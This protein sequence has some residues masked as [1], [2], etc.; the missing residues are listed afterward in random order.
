M[1]RQQLLGWVL[2][3]AW[4]VVI[5]QFG[6]SQVLGATPS[7]PLQ[8]WLLRKSMHLVVYGVLGGAL[9]LAM[10]GASRWPWILGL[11]LVI[12]LGD[13]T[14]QRF[15]PRRAFNLHDIGVDLLGGLVGTTV[16]GLLGRVAGVPT[17]ELAR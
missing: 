8:R 15:V 6:G 1:R 14:H 16:S 13:E 7:D 3:G 5:W 9:A 17:E 12:A 4:L 2:I 10:G 11:C